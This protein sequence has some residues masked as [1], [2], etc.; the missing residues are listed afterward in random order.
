VLRIILL[1]AASALCLPVQADQSC[2]TS[3]YPLSSPSERFVDNGDGTVTDRVTQLMWMRCSQGQQ[4]SEG[5]CS[6]APVSF[7]WTAANGVAE[8]LN[9]GGEAFYNDWRVPSLT[10]IAAIVERQCSE[11]RINL[12]VF[13]ETPPGIYWSSSPRPKDRDAVY[14]MG[15]GDQGVAPTAKDQSHYVRLV[16]TGP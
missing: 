4:W 15:F 12:E 2:D 9:D 8:Q 14:A 6:G 16:R 13:P 1:C 5:S 7:D 11:P 3:Q 10:E